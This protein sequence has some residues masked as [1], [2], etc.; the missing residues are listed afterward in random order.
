MGAEAPELPAS[1]M[2]FTLILVT[3]SMIVDLYRNR[4]RHQ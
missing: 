4:L 2:N 1:E 3:K